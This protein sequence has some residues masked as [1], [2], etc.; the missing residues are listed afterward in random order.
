[1]HV[2]RFGYGVDIV[3][4]HGWGMHGAVLADFARG[5][6]A[7]G[8]VHVPDLPGHGHSPALPTFD[9]ASVIDALRYA[10][11][12]DAVWVGWSLGAVLA[13]L[14][15]DPRRA[16]ALVLISGVGR[17]TPG[18]GW[19]WG[20]S[21]AA[22]D[23]VRGALQDSAGAGVDALLRLVAAAG[24]GGR[25]SRRLLEE[26][27]AE[28]PMASASTLQA[29]LDLLAGVDAR[30]ALRQWHRPVLILGGDRDPLV[31]EGALRQCADG[32]ADATLKVLAGAGHVPFISHPGAVLAAVE[33]FLCRVQRPAVSDNGEHDGYG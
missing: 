24:A 25:R 17:F 3:L 1:M 16:R 27:L 6:G 26:R 30:P 31:P 4:V 7:R 12:G 5:L 9:Q 14:A 20:V 18:P 11:P 2:N 32:M 22:L 15:A 28:R 13:A 10:L 29:A 19:P 21:A 23:D 8:R 33:K